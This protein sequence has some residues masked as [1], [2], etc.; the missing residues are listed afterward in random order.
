MALQGFEKVSR[1]LQNATKKIATDSLK[2]A[3]KGAIVIRRDMDK[4][5][6]LIPIDTGNLRSSWFVTLFKSQMKVTMGFTADY[7]PEVHENQ[8]ASFRRPG[9]GAKFFEAAMKR[10]LDEILK[11][12]EREAKV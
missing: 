9:S 12:I 3:L 1:N 11:T 6:P 10:N 8:N 4:T 2:G 5:P 7:A